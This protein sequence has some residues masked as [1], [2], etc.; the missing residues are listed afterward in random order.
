MNADLATDSTA[1]VDLDSIIDQL[2][3]CDGELPVEAIGKVREHSGEITPLLIRLIEDATRNCRQ[4]RIIE[5]SGHFYAAYLLAEFRATE[6]WPAVRE[7]ISLPGEG[8]FD[9]FGDAITEDFGFII[10]TLIGDRQDVVDEM[11]ADRSLNLYVRWQMVDALLF[12]VRD[13]LVTR[14]DAIGRLESH[15]KQAIGN[16]EEAVEGLVVRLADLGAES[17]LPL[18]EQAF[19]EDLIDEQLVSLDEV[20][21]D[22]GKADAMFDETMS[23]MRDVND[24]VARLQDWAELTKDFDESDL[25]DDFP[26]TLPAVGE[27]DYF[28]DNV[29]TVRNEGLKI[30]RNESCPCGSGK[31]HKKC[32]GRH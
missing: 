2:I 23:S 28:S 3:E 22:V 25:A 32:C 15:L 20:R 29:A 14:E 1:Q 30:G 21:T 19:H 13:G 12:H 27:D 17:A 7:A 5:D 26:E 4:G 11:I 31:K 10:S 9:L 8:P 16:Q 24:M 6:A 18:I